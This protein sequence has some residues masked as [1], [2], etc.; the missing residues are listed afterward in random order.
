[1][2]DFD[3]ILFHYSADTIFVT[4]LHEPSNGIIGVNRK[5]QVNKFQLKV[6]LYYL[7]YVE[8][9]RFVRRSKEI[10]KILIFSI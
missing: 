4:A 8:K 5:G 3:I 2:Y 10:S 9:R 7:E 1:M 6:T